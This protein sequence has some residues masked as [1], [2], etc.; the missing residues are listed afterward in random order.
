MRFFFQVHKNNS[1]WNYNCIFCF[2][3]KFLNIFQIPSALQNVFFIRFNSFSD[4]N[5][6]LMSPQIAVSSS[7]ENLMFSPK[8]IRKELVRFWK[9]IKTGLVSQESNIFPSLATALCLPLSP[10]H[11]LDSEKRRPRPISLPLEGEDSHFRIWNCISLQ[12]V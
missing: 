1:V 8:R 6:F 7:F 4:N 12:K 11:S 9:P 2:H 5:R 10:R 3:F